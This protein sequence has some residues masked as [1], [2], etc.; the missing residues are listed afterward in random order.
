MT[1]VLTGF[2]IIAAIIAVGYVV[3]R[4]NLL[5]PDARQVIARLVFFVLAPSLLFTI[6]ADA[7]VAQLF[8]PLMV[9]SLIA[10]SVTFAVYIAVARVAWHRDASD[11]V[12]GALSAGYVNAN[13]IGIPVAVYVLGDAAYSAPVILVQLLLFAPLGLAVL[14]VQ[15]QGR[16][17][18]GRLISQPLRNPIIIG[19]ALGLVVTLTGLQVPDSV[20]E[21]FRII[22]AAAVPLMLITYGMSLHGQKILEPGVERRDAVLASALK[23]L[24]MPAV[25]WLCG[26]FVFGLTGHDLF[27]VVALA[28]LPTAQ[29]VFNYAQRYRRG[30]T[31]ARDAIFVTTIGAVPVLIV[32][33]ALLR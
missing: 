8:S 10:A 15:Q 12:I 21:P 13:N 23:L 24:V 11:A 27:V 25:A 29:N 19:S 33:A 32:V 18:V 3:G 2:A 14:D 7:E 26:R 22:G 20:M 5:G 28:A 9:V 1:G 17:S 16:A 31:L 6:L 4:V 30:E